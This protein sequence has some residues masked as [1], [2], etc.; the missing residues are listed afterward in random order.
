[1]MA[2]FLPVMYC[3][4]IER[5]VGF[6]VLTAIKLA[7]VLVLLVMFK[8]VLHKFLVAHLF[9]AFG[10][11]RT[12]CSFAFESSDFQVP[13]GLY[14]CFCILVCVHKVYCTV[15]AL[16]GVI[17]IKHGSAGTANWIETFRAESWLEDRT[18][19]IRTRD[20][21]LV[22]YIVVLERKWNIRK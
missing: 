11:F 2:V 8:Q 16:L 4:L 22:S 18:H 17:L 5:F 19:A 21:I 9:L 12:C 6:F 10:N 1:M 3:Q 14:D 15:R 7:P 13:F 20:Q